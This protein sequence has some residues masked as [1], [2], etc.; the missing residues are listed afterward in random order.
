MKIQHTS[1]SPI[2][3]KLTPNNPAEILENQERAKSF[4]QMKILHRLKDNGVL[5]VNIDPCGWVDF[6][7]HTGE[8]PTIYSGIIRS[9]G[10]IGKIWHIFFSDNEEELEATANDMQ[11][12]KALF[13]VEHSGNL[14]GK[15]IFFTLDGEGNLGE[16][17]AGK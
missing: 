16:I 14:L 4:R 15:E 8:K 1:D 11:R 12:L 13:R 2:L 5:L 17:M 9:V 10:A 3:L 6:T 7:E